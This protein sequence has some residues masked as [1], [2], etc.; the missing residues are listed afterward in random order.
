MDVFVQFRFV[1]FALEHFHSN[2][3]LV[4]L[5]MTCERAFH[6]SLFTMKSLIFQLN[7]E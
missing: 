7:V 6:M 4:I 1:K 3:Q 2:I 5:C